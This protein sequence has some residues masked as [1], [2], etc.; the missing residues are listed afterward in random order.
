MPIPREYTYFFFVALP[1]L[2]KVLIPT[3]TVAACGEAG[4]VYG[5][6]QESGE[7]NPASLFKHNLNDDRIQ[8]ESNRLSITMPP[9]LKTL[10]NKK[11]GQE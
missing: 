3:A 8:K 7:K 10:G 5:K 11:E 2:K 1:K 6:C 9:V 4:Y